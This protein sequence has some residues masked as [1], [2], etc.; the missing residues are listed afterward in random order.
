[1]ICSLPARQ[2]AEHFQ[3][4]SVVGG[5][6]FASNEETDES[7]PPR[8]DDFAVSTDG[9][10]SSP[11]AVRAPVPAVFGQFQMSSSTGSASSDQGRVPSLAAT[12]TRRIASRGGGSIRPALRVVSALPG[13]ANLGGF[14]DESL[15]STDTTRGRQ[16]RT[17]GPRLA[18]TEYAR[19]GN[20][21]RRSVS[22][23]SALA[24]VDAQE[25]FP[26]G[27]C[28]YVAK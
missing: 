26:E 21:A 27:A 5:D 10:D 16:F 11:L 13:N 3:V 7:G 22:Y 4:G 25:I 24:H 1:M 2:D 8:V 23:A 18:P 15:E 19:R 28:L 12:I 9:N 14:T 17:P 20:V 6:L